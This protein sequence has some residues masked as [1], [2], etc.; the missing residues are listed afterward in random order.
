MTSSDAALY[1]D[2]PS[3]G[4]SLWSPARTTRRFRSPLT[5]GAGAFSPGLDSDL[6]AGAV[7][8]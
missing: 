2:S 7:D 6:F 8:V 5:Q 1:A 4:R 3:V